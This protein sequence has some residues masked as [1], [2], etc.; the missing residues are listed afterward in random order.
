MG[1]KK[2]KFVIPD[3]YDILLAMIGVSLCGIG[4]GFANCAVL[5]LDSIGILY[6]GIR[7]VLGFSSDMLGVA[8]FIVSGI[9]I[10]FLFFAA[11]KYVSLGTLIHTIAYGSFVTVGMIIYNAIIS[12]NIMF[13]RILF[14]VIGYLLLYV[15]IGIYIAIDIGVDAFTGIVLY[16]ADITHIEMK[17]VK[18]AFDIALLI[19]GAILGGTLGVA[20]FVTM[21]VAGPLINL[22]SKQFQK[23][24]FKFKLKNMK[25][26]KDKNKAN[27]SK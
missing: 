13:I 15:G 24:Y 6:D 5:G 21:V 25:N 17:Y 26:R 9:L 1:K 11:R 18:I 4:V 2:T 22:F 14:C 27:K 16:L 12:D 23:L 3:I 10:V 19:I 8:S 20:S 7:N